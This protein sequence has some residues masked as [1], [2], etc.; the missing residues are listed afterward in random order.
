MFFKLN[1]FSILKLKQCEKLLGEMPNKSIRIN[2]FLID[3]VLDILII[4][5][6]YNESR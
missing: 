6:R 2:L 1:I 4:I 3:F 5:W